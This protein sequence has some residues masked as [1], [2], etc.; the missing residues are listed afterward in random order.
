[1]VSYQ[2]SY[3]FDV[4]TTADSGPA[5]NAL[6]SPDDHLLGSLLGLLLTWGPAFQRKR[7]WL[8]LARATSLLAVHHPSSCSLWLSKWSAGIFKLVARV[9][10]QWY[11]SRDGLCSPGHD[12]TFAASISWGLGRGLPP[13]VPKGH[14]RLDSVSASQ[15]VR[16]WFC[17]IC[18]KLQ[19]CP[20]PSP[21]PFLN[22]LK[23]TALALYDWFWLM[24]WELGISSSVKIWETIRWKPTQQWPWFTGDWSPCWVLVSQGIEAK[25]D[26]VRT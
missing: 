23:D 9:G 22:L 10:R 6:D 21:M 14:L 26:K 5:P 11:W 16:P 13:A 18:P 8:G 4:F 15:Q 20:A 2:P 12:P 24:W 1:M 25:Y 19:A 7:A 3:I 17:I